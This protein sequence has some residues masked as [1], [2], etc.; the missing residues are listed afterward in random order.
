VRVDVGIADEET[1]SA[2]DCDT[3]NE[4]LLDFETVTVVDCVA[5]RPPL[6]VPVAI[7]ELERVRTLLTD[8][9]EVALN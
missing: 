9:L 4:L 7:D 3:V 6:R 8:E 2:L 1:E 5:V